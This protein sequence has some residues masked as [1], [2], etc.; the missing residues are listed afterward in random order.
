MSC[1]FAHVWTAV[2]QHLPAAIRTDYEVAGAALDGLT[3]DAGTMNEDQQLIYTIP[4]SDTEF[5][6]SKK[7][8]AAGVA[9]LNY[10]R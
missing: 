9:A 10:C 7:A 8:P 3:M 5:V 4:G 1:V 2:E 6:A